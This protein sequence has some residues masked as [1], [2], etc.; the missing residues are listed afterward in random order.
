MLGDITNVDLMLDILKIMLPLGIGVIVGGLA[1]AR[2]VG[3]LLENYTRIVYCLIL[4]LIIGSI[5]A[6]MREPMVYES[7]TAAPMVIAAVITFVAGFA[8]SFMLGR[9]KM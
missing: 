1:M 7:G 2:L 5:Y 4:G 8:A 6:L 9:K 3:K